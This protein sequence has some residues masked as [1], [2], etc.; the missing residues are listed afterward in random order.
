MVMRRELKENLKDTKKTL[1]ELKKILDQA[2]IKFWL[3]CGT[4]L[5]AVRNHD[6]I[7]Y[8]DDI[9]LIVLAG[10]WNSKIFSKLEIAGFRPIFRKIQT[11]KTVYTKKRGI[12]IDLFLYYYYFPAD[13]F[14]FPRKCHDPKFRE[15]PRNL[16]EKE[17]FIKFLGEKF[18]IPY[19]SVKLLTSMYGSSWKTPQKKYESSWREQRIF[20]PI[21]KDKLEKWIAKHPKESMRGLK[22]NAS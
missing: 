2:D 8:D 4:L 16:L 5:G 6:F 21:I 20:Q 22:S 9:D 10:D 7:P 18:R 3:T 11:K 12:P 14:V 15:I 13:S 19:E 1:L 17:T